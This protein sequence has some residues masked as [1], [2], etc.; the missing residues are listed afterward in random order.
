[1]NESMDIGITQ[2][3]AIAMN[4]EM[5][6]MLVAMRKANEQIARAI[7]WKLTSGKQR[8]PRFWRA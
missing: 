4:A 8:R 7:K 1:M 3:E 2:E 5:E 6:R